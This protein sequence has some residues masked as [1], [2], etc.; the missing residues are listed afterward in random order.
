MLRGRASV[1]S[2]TRVSPF[3]RCPG[4]YLAD[5]ILFLN[6]AT[7][8]WALDISLAEGATELPS[9]DVEKW[10]TFITFVIPPPFA[11]RVQARDSNVARLL[12]EGA[13]DWIA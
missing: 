4:A 12:K 11:C 8:V 1:L 13:G 2:L 10:L 9:D 3:S 7:F 6:I 5:P